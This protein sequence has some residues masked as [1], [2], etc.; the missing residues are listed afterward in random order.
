VIF[1]FRIFIGGTPG[2]WIVGVVFALVGL[3]IILGAPRISATGADRTVEIAVMRILGAFFSGFGALLLA[4]NIVD[5][6]ANKGRPERREEWGRRL[7]FLGGM[8]G[9]AAFAVP[10]SLMLPLFL[11][12]YAKRPNVLFPAGTHDAVNNLVV[13]ALFSVLGLLGLWLMAYVLRGAF[14]GRPHGRRHSSRVR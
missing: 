2:R 7:S 12:A 8:L 6:V 10:S 13:A 9:A 4:A 11:I 14:T 5:L 3:A 1:G